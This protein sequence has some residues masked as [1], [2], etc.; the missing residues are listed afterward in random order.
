[1]RARTKYLMIVNQ[2]WPYLI[3]YVEASIIDYMATSKNRSPGSLR[4]RPIA[5]ANGFP[6]HTSA[7]L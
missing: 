4:K 7:P 2:L 3:S 6:L 1:M 5:I